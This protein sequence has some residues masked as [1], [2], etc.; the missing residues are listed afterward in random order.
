MDINIYKL[1]GVEKQLKRL[2]DN[3]ELIMLHSLNISPVSAARTKST[4]ESAVTYTDER[5]DA[6]REFL[7]EMGRMEKVQE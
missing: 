1:A 2:N 4:E 7:E 3:L 5:D 6:E